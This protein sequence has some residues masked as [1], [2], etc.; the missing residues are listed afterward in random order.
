MSIAP[1]LIKELTRRANLNNI[2]FAIYTSGTL[3]Q[4]PIASARYYHR[5]IN[6]EKAIRTGFSPSQQSKTIER[7]MSK[8]YAIKPVEGIALY[9]LTKKKC[10][11]AL[12]FLNS[13]HQKLKVSQIFTIEQFKHMFLSQPHILHT[14]LVY[15]N[16]EIT[17]LISYYELNSSIKDSNEIFRTAFLYYYAYSDEIVFEKAMNKLLWEL[18][19]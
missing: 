7:A 10:K 4:K 9:K 14:Y 11:Q 18:K 6:R 15:N 13:Y 12:D 2:F 17:A 19:E 3:F 5:I 16:S 8:L 1:V